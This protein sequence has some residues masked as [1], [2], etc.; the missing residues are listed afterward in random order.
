MFVIVASLG[1][2]EKVG[3]EMNQISTRYLVAHRLLTPI[4]HDI[5]CGLSEMSQALS[6]SVQNFFQNLSGSTEEKH[7]TPPPT[8]TV[9]TDT[10]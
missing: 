6:V 8:E 4:G 10:P 1:Y 7:T 2:L 3:M 5:S 9:E